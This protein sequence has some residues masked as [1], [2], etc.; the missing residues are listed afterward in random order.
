MTNKDIKDKIENDFGWLTPDEK[1]KLNS[2][3]ISVWNDA[4]VASAKVAVGVK[5][6]EDEYEEFINSLILKP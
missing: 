2:L 4:V 5:V 1:Q 3:L 6:S